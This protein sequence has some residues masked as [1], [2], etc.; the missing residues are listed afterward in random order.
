VSAEVLLLTARV[1]T[2]GAFLILGIRNIGNHAMLAELM[3]TRGV[4]LPALSATAGIAMQIGFGGLMITGI[5]QVVAALGLAVF[6][7]TAT[8]IAHWPFDK[9]G[10]E[11]QEN[12]TACLGNAI[13]LGGLLAQ[14]ATKL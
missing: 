5:A 7:I 4:P 10:A 13:M 3:R 14:A 12:I 8:A 1:L 11:R 2:G 6:A 9:E